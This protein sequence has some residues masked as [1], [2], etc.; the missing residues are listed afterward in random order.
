[1]ASSLQRFLHARVVKK[2]AGRKYYGAFFYP[3]ELFID[4]FVNHNGSKKCCH[5]SDFTLVF[6]Y[7]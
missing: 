7:N 5:T 6:M 1:M 4:C 3:R 2:V